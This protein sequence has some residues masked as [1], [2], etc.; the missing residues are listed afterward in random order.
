M[1]WVQSRA[2]LA[3]QAVC[4]RNGLATLPSSNCIRMQCHED[5]ATTIQAM[6]IWKLHVIVR[7]GK[8]LQW[9]RLVTVNLK[10]LVVLLHRVW[11]FWSWTITRRNHWRRLQV[12]ETCLFPSLL[13]LVSWYASRVCRSPGFSPSAYSWRRCTVDTTSCGA[14]YSFMYH[15]WSVYQ[16]C[17]KR[18]F[19]C[20]HQ[21]WTKRWQSEGACSSWEVQV[22]V[23]LA[24]ISSGS[25]KIS[26]CVTDT[27][28]P[29]ASGGDRS[30]WSSLCVTVVS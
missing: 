27:T 26:G 19:G 30:R 18:H 2:H 28:I 6:N 4:R 1:R 5:C 25:A 23:Y 24:W 11:V 9:R 7:P 17:W 8:V 13:G 12:A 10:L 14:N 29:G 16:P 20:L 15:G 3:T 21:P 22:C